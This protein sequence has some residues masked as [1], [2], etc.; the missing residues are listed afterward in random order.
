MDDNKAK[1]FKLIRIFG[2]IIFM[3]GAVLLAWA[4]TETMTMLGIVLMLVGVS[5]VG[6]GTFLLKRQSG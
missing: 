2:V 4:E 1:V 3:I 5:D 6:I